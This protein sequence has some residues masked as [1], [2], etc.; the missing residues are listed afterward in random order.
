M[1]NIEGGATAQRHISA[2]LNSQIAIDPFNPPALNIVGAVNLVAF[3][4]AV[5]LGIAQV[6]YTGITG[7]AFVHGS[8]YD[9]IGN[10]VISALGGGPTYY[11]GDSPGATSSGGQYIP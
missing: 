6:A 3:I 11:P 2:Q 7:K 8:Q 5:A 4:E 9:A 1:I 10:G